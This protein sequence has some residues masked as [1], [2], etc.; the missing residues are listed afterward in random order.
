MK[1]MF[2]HL[3]KILLNIY[4]YIYARKNNYTKRK[5]KQKENPP[6]K[7]GQKAMNQF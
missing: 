5:K 1:I 3:N 6:K 7:E 4:I 2:L